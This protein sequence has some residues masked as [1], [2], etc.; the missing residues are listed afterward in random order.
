VKRVE[1]TLITNKSLF[2]RRAEF[3]GINRIMI[4]LERFGK[5]K[6]QCGRRFFLSDHHPSD[7]DLIRA[8]LFAAS[9]QV[10]V[11]PWTRKAFL[12]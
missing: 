1:L 12:K 6:R 7:I 3:A 4:D 8:I 10:R 2:A 9:V 5:A 11:N